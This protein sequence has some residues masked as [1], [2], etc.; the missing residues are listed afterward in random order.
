M[1]CPGCDTSAG[2]DVSYTLVPGL[3][4]GVDPDRVL[5]YENAARHGDGGFV[6]RASGAVDYVRPYAR[7]GE[8]IQRGQ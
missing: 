6:L 4:T 1:Q 2:L 3:T 7:I 5:M 8:M